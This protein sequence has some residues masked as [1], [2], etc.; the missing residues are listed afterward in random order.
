MTLWQQLTEPQFTELALVYAFLGG[1]LMTW[2]LI[3][4]KDINDHQGPPGGA[5]A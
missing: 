1:C 3:E 4:V 2:L 5:G